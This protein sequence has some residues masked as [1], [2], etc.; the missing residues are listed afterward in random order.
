RDRRGALKICGED[1]PRG[2][3]ADRS[4]RRCRRFN[5]RHVA[6][7]ATVVTS[8]ITPLHIATVGGHP[9]RFFKTPLDGGR[10]DFPWHA[11]DDVQ[12]CLG[13][14]R[15]GRKIFLHKLR[16]SEWSRMVRTVATA[17]GVITVAPHFIAQGT[18]DAM[19][20]PARMT[21]RFTLPPDQRA[22]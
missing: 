13:L 4:C 20:E 2:T 19:V 3:D 17:D 1:Q 16:S 8:I 6:P 18:I 5:R 12:R 7:G 21:G 22:A 14:N 15:Q 11:V 10:P 9:L